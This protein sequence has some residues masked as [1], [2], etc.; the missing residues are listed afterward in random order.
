MIKQVWVSKS[1][2]LQLMFSILHTLAGGRLQKYLT[3]ILTNSKFVGVSQRNELRRNDKPTPVFLPENPRTG[4]SSWKSM[5]KSSVLG[6]TLCNF[7]AAADGEICFHSF[8]SKEGH[9]ELGCSD[10]IGLSHILS[11][12]KKVKWSVIYF[13]LY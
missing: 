11:L 13:H 8:T 10:L 2:S 9:T 4:G 5:W 12:I 3:S 6:P 7:A 1:Q